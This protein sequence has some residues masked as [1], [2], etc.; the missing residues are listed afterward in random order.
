MT[1]DAGTNHVQLW[2]PFPDHVECHAQIVKDLKQRDED[3]KIQ[4]RET[5]ERSL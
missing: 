3:D 5:S 1:G 4:D 2:N